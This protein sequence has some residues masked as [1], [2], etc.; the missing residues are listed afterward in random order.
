ME[1]KTKNQYSYF[2]YPYLVDKKYYNKHILKLLR[3]K[4]C[5]VKLFERQRDS[6]I[7]TYFNP[8][9]RKG[10]FPS[11]EYNKLQV[12]KFQEFDETMKAKVLAEGMCSMFEYDL[13]EDVQG[14]AGDENGIFFKIQK[15]EI[16]CFNSGICFILIKT[17]IENSNKFSEVL[18]FNYK[19]RDINSEFSNSNGYENINIQTD[20]LEDI[21]KLSEIIEDI[22]GK[23]EDVQAIDVDTNRFLT[24]SYACIE[25]EHWNKDRNF[26]EIKNEFYKYANILPSSYNLS[27]EEADLPIVSKWEYTKIGITKMGTTLMSS[28][29]EEDKL[30]EIPY[31]YE[32]QLIYT[33]IIALYQRLR[34]KQLI[35]EFKETNNLIEISQKLIE[36]TRSL[37]IKEITHDELGSVLYRKWRDV[38]GLTFL[39]KDLK[40]IYEIKYKQANIEKNNFMNRIL[41]FALCGSITINVVNYLMILSSR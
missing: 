3:N 21:K 41:I 2:I 26:N 18:D 34:L 23:S 5:K 32:N 7:F 19:F 1:L 36:F 14:K 9:I 25:P 29:T 10:V 13:G 16:I 4:K 24:Y 27:L 20:S 8:T 35:K 15:I 6:E 22:S 37:W 31:M 28:G 38:L 30:T 12:K 17:K 39:Y 40:N 11:L 33:Y